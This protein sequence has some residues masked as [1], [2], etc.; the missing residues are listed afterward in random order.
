MAL[1]DIQLIAFDLDGT[2]LDSVPD[3]AVAADQTVQSLG[4]PSVSEEEV[5]DWVG[6]GAD[7]LIG[8]ALSRNIVV[9]QALDTDVWKEARIRFDDFYQQ[10]GHKLS[11]LYA[12]VTDTLKA[13]HGSGFKLALV[14]NK[15]SKFV[16]DVLAQHGI[17]DLFVDVIGGDTFEQKKPD[18]MALNWL[19]NKH[20]VTP[21]QMLMVGDSKNDILAAKNA[22]CH[23]FALTYGYNHGEPI[24]DSAPDFVAD[25]IAEMLD[26]L[27]VSQ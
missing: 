11:H 9:D 23:S 15:P 10:G 13:L 25:N 16:P 26:V 3:L 4:F 21:E 5:R 7:I 8:R 20:Q 1:Q 17:A 27:A 2:L 6:N 12:N 24:S 14:T 18:P 19:L 22:G